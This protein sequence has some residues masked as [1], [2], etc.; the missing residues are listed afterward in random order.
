MAI[1]TDQIQQSAITPAKQ[2]TAART[3]VA[4]IPFKLPAPTGS[5]QGAWDKCIFSVSKAFTIISVKIA[6]DTATSGSGATNNYSFNAKNITGSVNLHTSATT[7]EGA[8]LSTT[9]LKSITVS[10]NLSF[11]ANQIFS[12]T[13]SI[14]DDGSAGPTNLSAAQLYAVVEYSI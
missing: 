11:S 7:T 6:S 3:R 1:G 8:E 10:Q 14:L 2:T 5:N 13:A 9:A 4:V 12:I